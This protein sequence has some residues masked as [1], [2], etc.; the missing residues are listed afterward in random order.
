MTVA[1]ISTQYR[2][3]S[4]SGVPVG[5]RTNISPRLRS[6]DAATVGFVW[7]GVFRGDETMPTI[8][9]MLQGRHV[10]MTIV[11]YSSFPSLSAL[12][13]SD[14]EA[15]LQALREA[16]RRH[17]VD[18]VVVGNACC[19]GCSASATRL[20]VTV[21]DAGIPVVVVA[22]TQFMQLVEQMGEMDGRS[23]RVAEY[24][25]TISIEAPDLI[26]SNL[27]RLTVNQVISGLTVD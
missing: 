26:R 2:V 16:I 3:V 17:D 21:E 15:R 10:D 20:A 8:A 11:P 14:Q 9:E 5:G 12:G 24:P 25:G 13:A 18:A 1:A 4:P 22:A 6:L 23:L 7:N 27:E 19:G